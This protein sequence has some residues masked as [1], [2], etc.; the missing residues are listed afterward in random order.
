[1]D[2]EKELEGEFKGLAEGLLNT[3]KSMGNGT[4]KL[5]DLALKLD[6]ERK[7]NDNAELKRKVEL[8]EKRLEAQGISLDEFTETYRPLGISNISQRLSAYVEQL[9]DPEIEGLDDIENQPTEIEED[10]EVDLDSLGEGAD[11][12]SPEEE[13]DLDGLDA[14]QPDEIELDELDAPQPDEIELDE[15]DPS[16]DL[17]DGI[18]LDLGDGFETPDIEFDEPEL[19]I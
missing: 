1:M 16:L 17:D 19:D 10:L 8:L 5:L 9:D 11:L 12:E 14:P 3:L 15:L 13:I 2:A 4:M 6:D 7:R 18:D